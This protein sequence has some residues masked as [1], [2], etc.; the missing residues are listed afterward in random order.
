MDDVLRI[1]TV[2]FTLST[3]PLPTFLPLTQRQP[4]SIPLPKLQPEPL[5]NNT[6]VY[7]IQPFINSI[8]KL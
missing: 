8:T 2:F 1:S 3:Y 4:Q 7:K 5:L 6:L